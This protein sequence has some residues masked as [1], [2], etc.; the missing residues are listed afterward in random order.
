VTQEPDIEIDKSADL[1][2]AT[3]AGQ[4]ITYT[5]VV[6]NTGNVSLTNITVTDPLPGLSAVDC[7][8]FD[9]VLEPGETVTCDAT[10]IVTQGHL[11]AGDPITNTATA[12]GTPPEGEDVT[13]D[14][15]EI[16]EVDQ[17]A[18]ID[19]I[20]TAN[21]A[22]VNS[23]GQI[24]TYTFRVENVGN[25]TLSAV[26]V[27]DNLVG[28]I[29]CGTF[30][31]IL[32]PGEWVE[33][34]ATYQ[35]VQADINA[36]SIV[37]IA[38]TTGTP[39]GDL[40]D[41]TDEDAE[42]VEVVLGPDDDASITIIKT[43][44]PRQVSEAGK[45]ITYTFTVKN[46]GVYTLTNVTVTDN[47]VG[48]ISCGTFSGTLQPGQS[49]VCTATYTVKQADINAGSITNVATAKGTPP[50]GSDVTDTDNEL[51]TVVLGP[52]LPNTG[53]DQR[54]VLVSVGSATLGMVLTVFG[55]IRRRDEKWFDTTG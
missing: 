10:L 52:E 29:D 50:E 6:E 45:V 28:A 16:V 47:L 8:D 17:D 3:A 36:G 42:V 24:V 25:V 44:N 31:G 51:V 18:D 23:T 27:I 53:F 35:V 11:D 1:A 37:N 55:I 4:T 30:D 15:D 7:G 54:V 9:G 33:C 39:P 32:S 40:E 19:L 2:S 49:V 13:D 41:V 21:P 12:T 43:A 14:D 22:S 20:K 48:A 46:T 5:F 38:T 26:D 34:T